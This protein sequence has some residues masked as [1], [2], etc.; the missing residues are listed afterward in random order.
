MNYTLLQSNNLFAEC[1]L[2]TLGMNYDNQGA[3]LSGNAEQKGVAS[4]RAVCHR[5]ACLALCT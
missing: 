5:S 1:F 4:V 3:P 2:R